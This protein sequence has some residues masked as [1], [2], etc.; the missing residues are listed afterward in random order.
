MPSDRGLYE[1]FFLNTIL[2][3]TGQYLQLAALRFLGE[4]TD[5]G[6]LLYKKLFWWPWL[7]SFRYPPPP[8]LDGEEAPPIAVPGTRWPIW[9]ENRIQSVDAPERSDHRMT[10]RDA[11]IDKLR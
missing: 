1:Y 8:H 7:S 6:Q 10:I 3:E 4:T 11:L 9:L 5:K 2:E